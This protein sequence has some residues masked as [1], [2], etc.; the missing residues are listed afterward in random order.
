MKNSIYKRQNLSIV[1][2]IAILLFMLN[3]ENEDKISMN[4]TESIRLDNYWEVVNV[5][6]S[7]IWVI[8]HAILV[9]WVALQD[10]KTPIMN[11]KSDQ[12]SQVD[13]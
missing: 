7:S 10:A 12:S 4:G 11:Y 13:I 6:K 5:N 8:D 2:I 1:E 9:A 3:L